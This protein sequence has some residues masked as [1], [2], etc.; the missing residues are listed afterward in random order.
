MSDIE[1]INPIGYTGWDSLV[2]SSDSYSFFHSS[3]WARVLSESYGYKPVYFT[4]FHKGK[5]LFLIPLMEIKTFLT[6]KRAVSLPF[7][8]YV[9][10]ILSEG[11]QLQDTFNHITACAKKSGW[12]YIQFRG[13]KEFVGHILPSN[14]Y[15]T[16][17]LELSRNTEVIFRKFRSSTKRN[18]KKAIKENVEVEI[19]N[20]SESIKKF[21]RLHCT[22]R[23]KHG[24]PP[25]P[26]SFF[27]KVFD[28]IISKNKGF[29]VFSSYKKKAIAAN[30]YFHFG[31]KAFYKFGASDPS[32]QKLRANN[33][34]MW[35]AI[36]WYCQNGY[37]SFCFGRTDP[38]NKG[39]LQFKRGWGVK[40]EILN[41]YK[42]NIN[43]DRFVAQK[44]EPVSFYRFFKI[45]PLSILRLSG[46]ILY[47][48]VG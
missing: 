21:Y 44:S 27:E 33:L 9:E 15:Y 18:I 30:V 43:S 16:H 6:S 34:V 39:L 46:N 14:Y 31:E 32:Y 8:D 2:L 48:H 20:S 28:H 7:S 23:K 22:T 41:Y 12:K 37:K 40:E 36:K 24:V 17:S 3:A 5:I 10:P 42:Y 13:V 29:V 26:F 19:C 38:D 11:F 47:R 45:M 1:I 25:Q 4:S 35:N